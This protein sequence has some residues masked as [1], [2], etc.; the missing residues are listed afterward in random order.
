MSRHAILLAVSLSVLLATSWVNASHARRVSPSR[1]EVDIEDLDSYIRW[2][3]SQWELRVEYE[4]EIEHASPAEAFDLVLRLA[5]RRG[6]GQP[7]QVVVP[8]SVPT[9]VNPDEV[10]LKSWAIVRLASGLVADPRKL[11][12]YAVV[13]PRGGGPV[14]D[15]EDDTVSFRH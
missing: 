7:V 1:A 15:S 12:L 4:V 2:T 9:E 14:L 10:E 13:V 3:G 5:D 6:F 8:L 11:S